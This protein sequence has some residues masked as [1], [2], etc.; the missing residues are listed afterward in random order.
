MTDQPEQLGFDI[1]Q[2]PQRPSEWPDPEEVR[3][4]M[5][6]T[7]AI[8]KRALDACPWDERTFRYHK[9]VFPQ[10]AYWLPDDEAK[11]LCFEFAQEV[12]RIEQ[13]MAA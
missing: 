13:L 10:M 1:F 8:A 3:A 11:Q 4:T 9:Q 5:L 6:G 12:A 7:L 2:A